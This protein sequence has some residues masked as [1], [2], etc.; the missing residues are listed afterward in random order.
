MN[1]YQ[2]IRKYLFKYLRYERHDEYLMM[3]DTMNND[4]RLTDEECMFLLNKFHNQTNT[5]CAHSHVWSNRVYAPMFIHAA[6]LNGIKS[7]VCRM[8]PDHVIVFDVLFESRGNKVDWH[9]DHESLGPFINDNPLSAILND[10]YLSVHFNLTFKGGNLC[11]L[12]W[13]LLSYLHHLVNK[14]FDIF[15]LSWR[16]LNILTSPIADCLCVQKSNTL[17]RGNIFNNL[18]LH[19]VSKGEK[20]VSYVLRL[21]RKKMVYTSKT[22]IHDS[23]KTSQDCLAFKK[24]LSLMPPHISKNEKICASDIDWEKLT[25]PEEE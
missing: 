15:S 22:C 16:I 2:Y 6:A 25:I 9:C 12:K 17:G 14:N 7:Q 20:R 24:F 23:V 1:S 21:V 19:S 18:A 4:L 10:D 3:C 13:P 11:V 5:S 8:L